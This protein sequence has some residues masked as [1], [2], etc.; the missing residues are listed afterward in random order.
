M[1]NTC[2]CCQTL[3]KLELSQHIFDEHSNIKFNKIPLNDSGDGHADRRTDVTKLLLV[4]RNFTMVPKNASFTHIHIYLISRLG[5]P[6]KMGRYADAILELCWGTQKNENR[7]SR[8]RTRSWL[9]PC[10]VRVEI[11]L[12]HCVGLKWQRLWKAHR[13]E[14]GNSNWSASMASG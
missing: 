14:C 1:Y 5:I 8:H 11:C 9:K 12:V 13:Q 7:L 6:M 10:T 3:R 4:F 2:Y